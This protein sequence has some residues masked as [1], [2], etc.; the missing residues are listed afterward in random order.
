MK[1][2]D[3]SATSGSGTLYPLSGMSKI[4]T[5]SPSPQG[6][7]EASQAPQPFLHRRVQCPHCEARRGYAPLAG[8]A[9]GGKCHACGTFDPPARAERIA[10]PRTPPQPK[11]PKPIEVDSTPFEWTE[12]YTYHDESGKEISYVDR[13]DR[14]V[15]YQDAGG[16]WESDKTY[17][18]RPAGITRRPR[19]NGEP[20]GAS[21][22][23][24]RMVLYNLPDV[25]SAIREGGRIWIV[26]GER[27]ANWL[28]DWLRHELGSF[29]R[30]S[31]SACGAKRWRA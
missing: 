15:L 9:G 6:L 26:E 31:T 1:A 19:T 17:R 7:R 27:C 24:V 4:T 22:E 13:Y 12:T 25:L 18:P 23:G 10:I 16:I 8:D 20:F 21:M 30:S 14:K 3:L 11:Q 29:D 2:P 5:L 28:G